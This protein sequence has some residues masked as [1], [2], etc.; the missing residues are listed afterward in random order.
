MR[1]AAIMT[2]FNQGKGSMMWLLKS[3]PLAFAA[4]WERDFRFEVPAPR[5]F[6]AYA[7][8]GIDDF[9]DLPIDLFNV[10]PEEW[11][12]APTNNT[13]IMVGQEAI[14]ATVSPSRGKV[15][16]IHRS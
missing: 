6:D 8:A 15:L 3:F 2:L 14:A 12:E 13:M 11:P 1:D 10:P 5:D 16:Q 4:L 7:S 9:V